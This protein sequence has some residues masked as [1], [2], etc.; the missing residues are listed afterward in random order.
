[1]GTA[2]APYANVAKKATAQCDEFRP[3]IA[4]LSPF[5]IPAASIKMCS[6]SIL[7]AISLYWY[8]TPLKSDKATSSQCSRMLFSIYALKLCCIFMAFNNILITNLRKKVR[9]ENNLLFS[10]DLS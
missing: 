3:H 8:E 7:R 1:M 9:L 5:C 6:F 4:I 2:T 10:S